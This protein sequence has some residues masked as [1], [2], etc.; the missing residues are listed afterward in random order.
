MLPMASSMAASSDPASRSDPTRYQSQMWVS[1]RNGGP[2]A[3]PLVPTLKSALPVSLIEWGHDVGVL[4]QR[5]CHRAE[6]A[7]RRR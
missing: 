1:S 4:L 6:A 7:F 2:S 5:S 3:A